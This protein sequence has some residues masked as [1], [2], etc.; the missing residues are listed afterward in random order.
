MNRSKEEAAGT[1]KKPV[2]EDPKKSDKEATAQKA[3]DGGGWG[4]AALKVKKEYSF[5]VRKL[6]GDLLESE[7]TFP[8]KL[9]KIILAVA[10]FCSFFVFLAALQ[11]SWEVSKADISVRLIVNNMAT[12]VLV[13]VIWGCWGYCRYTKRADDTLMDFGLGIFEVTNTVYVVCSK[14]FP[15][16]PV[17]LFC[18]LMAITI[19][20]KLKKLHLFICV[21]GYLLL[22]LETTLVQ[23]GIIPPLLLP[24]K[25]YELTLLIRIIRQVFS[26]LTLFACCAVQTGVIEEYCSHVSGSDAALE[27]AQGVSDMLV[28]FDTTGAQALLHSAQGNSL[29][30][31]HTRLVSVFSKL[32]TSLDAFFK[33]VPRPIVE[34]LSRQGMLGMVGMDSIRIGITFTD[35]KSFTTWCTGVDKDAMVRFIIK[36]FEIQTNIVQA[37]RGMVDKYIGDCL[38]VMWGAPKPIGLPILRACC[39]ALAMDRATKLEELR[40]LFSLG[41][42][43]LTIRTGIHYGECIAGNMGT[44]TRV[45]YTVI[46]DPVNTAAR[47]EATNKDFGT[48]ILVSEDAVNADGDDMKQLVLRQITNV[49]VVGRDKPLCVYEVVGVTPEKD[50][51]E[52]NGQRDKTKALRRRQTVCLGHL[53]QMMPAAPDDAVA[54]AVAVP[55]ALIAEV[56][57]QQRA[58][59]SH[60]ID[61]ADSDSV[62]KVE[63][64]SHGVPRGAPA[65]PNPPSNPLQPPSPGEDKERTLDDPPR[66]PR[67]AQLSKQWKQQLLQ[68]VSDI[69]PDSAPQLSPRSKALREVEDIEDSDLLTHARAMCHV[70]S[71]EEAQSV[72]EFSV[73]VDR[74]VNRNFEEALPLLQ[75]ALMKADTEYDKEILRSM[76]QDCQGLR[77]GVIESKHK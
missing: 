44:L 76:I 8:I 61:L 47:L 22:A 29:T 53:P 59:G 56:G 26:V 57:E 37:F 72:K 33:Y 24:G 6:F 64:G 40:K 54:A 45:N 10:F 51:A 25:D 77:A 71:Q 36:Y 68:L 28:E 31:N 1:N 7:D 5:F 46:G 38:M 66:S 4:K 60:V 49:R 18:A 16:Q 62:P 70:V 17:F 30:D 35:I 69:E 20:T 2:E 41:F 15:Y 63:G 12:H 23:E 34:E 75:A 43:A 73:A 42:E 27:M 3:N 9:R 14:G 19:K 58:E 39:A 52:G 50:D 48:R 55:P 32:R 67:V 11:D 65:P 21:V 74:Y 13:L